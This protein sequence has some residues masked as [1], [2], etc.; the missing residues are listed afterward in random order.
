MNLQRLRIPFLTIHPM[1]ESTLWF[2]RMAHFPFNAN[3]ESI[4]RSQAPFYPDPLSI[5]SE[6]KLIFEEL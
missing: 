4:G 2:E 1:R 5:F 6:A 3:P